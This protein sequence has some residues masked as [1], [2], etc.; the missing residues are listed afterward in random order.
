MN[1]AFSEEQDQLRQFVRQFLDDKSP[2]SAVREQMDTEVGYDAAVWSQMA[3]QLGLQSLIVPE[4]H[5]GQGF[6][7]VELIV[8]L[9]EMGRS[10]LCAPYFST[11]VLGVNTLVHSGDE[12]AQAAHL[13]GIAAGG[14]FVLGTERHESRRIDNQLRGRSGR[15]GDPGTSKFFLSLRDDLMRIFGSDRMDGMLQKL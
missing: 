5:G 14:L 15:Q 1:F 3:D 2:E 11:V 13:P 12:A 6:G 4:A 8:V 9:E 10:L 7:Y